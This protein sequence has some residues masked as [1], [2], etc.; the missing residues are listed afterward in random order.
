MVEQRVDA[1]ELTR[2]DHLVVLSVLKKV[3]EKVHTRAHN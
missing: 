2:V 1:K 3:D